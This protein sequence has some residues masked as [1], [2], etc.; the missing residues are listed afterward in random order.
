M[1]SYSI[2]IFPTTSYLLFRMSSLQGRLPLCDP[3]SIISTIADP[4]LKDSATLSL[5]KCIDSPYFKAMKSN[6]R[7]WV[8]LA[9]GKIKVY[10]QVKFLSCEVVL[11]FLYWLLYVIL[12]YIESSLWTS[13]SCAFHRV[14]ISFYCIINILIDSYYNPWREQRYTK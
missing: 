10:F 5:A 13:F 12:Q 3:S 14:M 2:N 8:F 1:S 9:R 4:K 11:L 6:R 7:G